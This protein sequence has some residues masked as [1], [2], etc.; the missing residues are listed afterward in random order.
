MGP[1]CV[2]SIPFLG[3]PMV[4]RRLQLASTTCSTQGGHGQRT[5]SPDDGRV[6]DG[7][8][9]YVVDGVE[10]TR[11]PATDLN[12]E[13]SCPHVESPP[14]SAKLGPSGFVPCTVRC[15]QLCDTLGAMSSIRSQGRRAR[16]ALSRQEILTAALCVV[17]AEGLEGLTMRRLADELHCGTM[18]LYS[19]LSGRDDLLSGLVGL[20]I[21]QID[22]AYVPDESWQDCARRSVGVVPS[23]RS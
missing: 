8:A 12:P 2:T 22:L 13:L 18:T 11:L 20:V 17:D 14:P 21:E 4:G 16:G 10:R 19:H 23:P 15:T 7:N 1:P 5:V 6:G 9:R 3:Q